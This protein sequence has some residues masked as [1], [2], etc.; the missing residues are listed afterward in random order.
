MKRERVREEKRYCIYSCLNCV[1]GTRIKSMVGKGMK[2]A[3][4]HFFH[5]KLIVFHLEFED[6]NWWFLTQI[7]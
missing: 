2:G 4:F 6:T 5:F 3:S 7:T 1:W